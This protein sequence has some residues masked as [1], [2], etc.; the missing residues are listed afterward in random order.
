MD[1]NRFN[2]FYDT[3]DNG[4]GSTDT[5][6]NE[7]NAFK[8]FATEDDFNKAIKSEQSKAKNELLKEL[9][10]KNVQEAK[11]TFAKVGQLETQ[12]TEFQTKTTEWET[13]Y[14]QVQEELVVTKFN[15][16]PEL[17]EEALTLAKAKVTAEMPLDKALE[18]VVAK[19]PHLV[20]TQKRF[21]AV[22]NQKGNKDENN[23]VSESLAKKYPYLN[24]K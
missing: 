23:V 12:I 7:T 1:L 15:V 16:K 20:D 19:L 17:K 2:V 18:A 9:G 14:T 3:D 13:K 24:K 10:I 21:Q 6:A 8:T 22:G 4:G 5:K 11:E